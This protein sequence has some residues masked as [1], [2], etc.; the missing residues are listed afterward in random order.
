MKIDEAIKIVTKIRNG[1]TVTGGEYMRAMKLGIEASERF[2]LIREFQKSGNKSLAK[3]ILALLP[4]ET[5]PSQERRVP[6]Y[7]SGEWKG[8]YLPSETE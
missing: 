3:V 5:D 7:A 4:S 6:Y 1:E 2:E 8:E